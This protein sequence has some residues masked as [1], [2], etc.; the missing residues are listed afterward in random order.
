ML[1]HVVRNHGFAR[2]ALFALCRLMCAV[3]RSQAD[4]GF[5]KDAA[6]GCAV[7]KPNLRPSEVVVWKGSCQNGVAEGHGV[8]RWNASDGATVTFEGKFAQGKLQ[9]AGTMT[10]SGGDRYDCAVTS[11][12]GVR[13]WGQNLSGQLGDGT[14][15]DRLTPVAV[16]GF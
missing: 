2:S 3:P 13:C 8:A 16:V 5:V 14:T 7:F 12:G 1:G 9:G 15:Q 6:S 10:A 11:A 4:D